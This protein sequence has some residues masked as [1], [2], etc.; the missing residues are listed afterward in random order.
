MFFLFFVFIYFSDKSAS[1]RIFIKDVFSFSYSFKIN[2][3]SGK[4]YNVIN[5]LSIYPINIET[6]YSAISLFVL[7]TC[8]PGVAGLGTEGIARSKG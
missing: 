4:I 5:N 1:V 8:D 2:P 3:V 6:K 7:Y